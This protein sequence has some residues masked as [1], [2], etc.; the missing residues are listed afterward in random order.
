MLDQQ[1]SEQGAD[2]VFDKIL[3][4]KYVY[5]EVMDYSNI[6]YKSVSGLGNDDGKSAPIA[7]VEEENVL[8]V[9]YY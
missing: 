1:V 3:V 6:E 8:E 4:G 2:V 9:I 5:V 7:I